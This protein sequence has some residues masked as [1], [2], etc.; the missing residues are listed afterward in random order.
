MPTGSFTKGVSANPTCCV[1][2]TGNADGSADD[3][4]DISDAFAIVDYLGAS[5]SLSDCSGENDINIDGTVDIGD[6][7]A[8]IDYLNLT[9][10]LQSCPGTVRDVDGNI[11]LTV[12]IGAQV[13]MAENLKVTHYRNGD[14]V[15]NVTMAGTWSGLTTGAFCDYDNDASNV[16]NYGR[17]YNWYAATDSRKIAPYGWHVPTDA[18]MQTLVDYLGGNEVAGGKMKAAGA[19]HWMSPNTGATNESGF[20]GLPG[21]ARVNGGVYFNMGTGALFWSSKEVITEGGSFSYMLYNSPATYPSVVSK[22]Y[23]YSIRCVKD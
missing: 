20:S 3:V 8:V 19:T 9:A 12:T 18:E 13:W 15:P 23:G 17:L 10:P 1:N 4:T 16:A 2:T 21:G 14:A 6:L 7:F 11:Y 22:S 5:V